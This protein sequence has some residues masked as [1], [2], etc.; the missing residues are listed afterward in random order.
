MIALSDGSASIPIHK[1]RREINMHIENTVTI[2]LNIDFFEAFLIILK[3]KLKTKRLIRHKTLPKTIS[4]MTT[5][6]SF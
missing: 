2:I 5:L 4:S 1:K 3:K 6:L